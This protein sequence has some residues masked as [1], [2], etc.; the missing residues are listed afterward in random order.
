MKKLIYSG[1]ALVA[2]IGSGLLLSGCGSTT[3]TTTQTPTISMTRPTGDEDFFKGVIAGFKESNSSAT[4]NY[5]EVP[6]EDYELNTLNTLAAQTGPDIWTI[7]NDWVSKHYDKLLPIPDSFFKVDKNDKSTAVDYFKANFGENVANDVIVNNKVYGIP[8]AM[9]TM[10]IYYNSKLINEAIDAYNTV[11]DENKTE[12]IDG[13]PQTW[14]SFLNFVPYATKRDGSNIT[15]AGIAMGTANNVNRA[16]DILYLLMLQNGAQMVSPDNL[17]ATFNLDTKTS[18]GG[19]ANPGLSALD[20]YTSF[21]NSSKPNYSWNSSMPDSIQAF[22]D[23]KVAMIFGYGYMANT[24]KQLAPDLNYK[25]AKVP[26]ISKTA[27]PVNFASYWVETVTK[28]SKGSSLVFQFLKSYANK[29]TSADYATLKNSSNAYMQNYDKTDENPKNSQPANVK[30]FN[31]GKQPEK[32]DS[33]IVDMISNATSGTSHQ[34][35]LDETA[36]KITNLLR[37]KE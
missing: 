33:L 2:I 27:E 23:G 10:V 26:Q 16:T 21:S 11:A 32:F 18:A 31:K 22:V 20:F 19:S 25:T 14:D 7:R 30:T 24:I 29:N 4:I 8:L 5:K 9:D 28:S 36:T 6:F 13:I 15:Q 12:G 1:L 37:E 34:K 17:T 3:T 35:T